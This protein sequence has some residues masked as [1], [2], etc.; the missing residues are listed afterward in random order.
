[1]AIHYLPKIDY[2]TKLV[3][4]SREPIIIIINFFF[5]KTKSLNHKLFQPI[6]QPSSFETKPRL[7]FTNEHNWVTTINPPMMNTD[8]SQGNLVEYR[9]SIIP[10][11]SLSILIL[12]L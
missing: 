5:A 11:N 3:T 10:L 12:T 8:S 1:M 4:I 9:C 7:L 2:M 6:V